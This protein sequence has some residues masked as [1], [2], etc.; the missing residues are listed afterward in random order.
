MPS[1]QGHQYTS[2][3]YHKQVE[4]LGIIGGHSRKGNCHDACI[5]SFC[6]YFKS[7]CLYLLADNSV[8][9]VIQVVEEY[10]YFYNYHCFQKQ[11]NQMA[12]SLF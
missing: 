2:I 3:K 8:D 12:L 11:S 7:E 10:I 6:S 1:D 5:E 4:Q 9:E